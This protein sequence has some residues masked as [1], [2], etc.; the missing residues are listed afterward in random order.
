MN[1]KIGLIQI[2]GTMPN[3]ALMKLS[4][5]YKQKGFD[6]TFI[7]LSMLGIK[8]W[9]ASKI[10]V[11]GSGYNL[12]A[13]LPKEIEEITPD[14]EGFKLNYSLGFTSRG[15]FRNCDF[16]I[17]QEK[18][19][20]I[21]EANMDWIK[22]T[23]AILYDNNF[24]ASP[25]WK[26]KLQ[27]FIDNDIKVS[28]NQAMDIRLINEENARMLLKLKSYDWKFKKRTYYFAFDD[29]KL[30]PIIREKVAFLKSLGFNP[31]WL[32]FY[33]LCGFNSTHAEDLKRVEI[34]KGFG[35]I[36]Y[37]MKYNDR[38][39]DIWLNHFDRYVNM[40]FYQFMPLEVLSL[41]FLL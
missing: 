8:N 24:L 21:R 14:Y 32:M 22:H 16:C 9:I 6:V 27:Y 23:K 10:F 19:G 34:I 5:F 38:T 26:E 15:C 12:K 39:D 3:L 37:I 31:R 1:E 2:D 25:K 4:A 30:E 18:E 35:S 7:D 17:V 36:P 41:F 33:I 13:D 28:I 40:L 29:V 11:G 20:M